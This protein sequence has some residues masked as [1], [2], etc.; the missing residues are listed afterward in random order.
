MI[1]CDIPKIEDII[2]HCWTDPVEGSFHLQK[3]LKENIP[4]DSDVCIIDRSE[5]ERLWPLDLSESKIVHN[6]HEALSNHTGKIFYLSGDLNIFKRYNKW[7]LTTKPDR[8][9]TP[10]VFPFCF[11]PKPG[12]VEDFCVESLELT[13]SDE[14]REL[15]KQIRL[16]D[17]TK[18]F[19]N[20]T[21]SPKLLRLLLL[22]RYYHYQNFDYSFFPWH[23]GE[24]FPE[25]SIDYPLVWDKSGQKVKGSDGFY[26][27]RDTWF[28]SEP[29]PIRELTEFSGEWKSGS[30]DKI[31]FDDSMPQEVFTSCCDIVTESYYCNDSVFFTEKT[32]KE[33][34]FR[35]PF[36]MLGA[37]NQYKF[38]KK[39]GFVLYDE[40]FNYDFDDADN[41]KER[42]E[43]FCDQIDRYIHLSPIKFNKK[44]KILTEKIEYNFQLLNQKIL[45]SVNIYE[46]ISRCHDDENIFV[47]NSKMDK[48]FEDV[49]PQLE[50]YTTE[51]L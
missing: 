12:L 42:Y 6:I 10:I 1:F 37:K 28:L 20:L 40:I 19:I 30:K 31:F 3:Y 17:K 27:L 48:M 18:N 39:L 34:I 7:V 22:K 43:G 25:V 41:L 46:M 23:H 33:I 49:L 5:V 29:I 15:Y 11:F 8:K 26:Q 36:L 38:F 13:Y 50:D 21:C 47:E 9:V 24:N 44:L 4:I 16:K 14:E 51:V 32:F 35:R 45:E 2:P